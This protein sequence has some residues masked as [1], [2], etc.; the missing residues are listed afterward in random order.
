MGPLL[1]QIVPFA[2]DLNLW[3]LKPFTTLAFSLDNQLG[4]LSYLIYVFSNQPEDEAFCQV[5]HSCTCES[6]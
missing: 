3:N 2:T 6:S 1:E 4:D 5:L